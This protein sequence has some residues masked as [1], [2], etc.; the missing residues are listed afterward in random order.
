MTARTFLVRGLLAGLVAGL[1]TFFVAYAVG[2]PPVDAAIALEEAG[3]AEP[4]PPA[5]APDHEHDHAHQEAGGHSHG[6]E[7]GGI[8][9][10]TQKT[11]GLA[12]ATV[13]VGVAL[14][15]IVALAAAGVAGRLGRLSVVG[16]TALVT[17][18]GF[19]AFSLVPFL[20]YPAA[21]PAVGSGDTIGERTGYYFAFVLVSVIAVV[22]TVAAAR[23]LTARIGGYWA[24]VAAGAGYVVVVAVAAALLP[25]VNE[26]GDFPA[27]VLWE[28]RVGSL[29]TLAT[30]WVSLGVVLTALLRPLALP[31]PQVAAAVPVAQPA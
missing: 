1:L 2:E 25:A 27:D 26:L 24:T 20:K 15:G 11:W 13:A 22:L 19:L 18:L 31:S 23:V 28:F 6:D 8:S 4:A 9:R 3:S 21:P 29:L 12:T 10:T 7:E 14:G 16:S 5:T 17:A 30:M